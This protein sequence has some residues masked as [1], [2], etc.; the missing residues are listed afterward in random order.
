M[1]SQSVPAQAETEGAAGSP[2]S[3]TDISTHY[4][5]YSVSNGAVMLLGFISFPI[6][7]RFLDNAEFGILR[8]YDTLM[9]L[10]VALV[11]FGAPHAIV[12]FYPYDGDQDRMRAF[13]TN[14]VLLPLILSVSIWSIIAIALVLAQWWGSSALHPLF[15]FA[16]V[17]VL[18]LSNTNIVQMVMRASERSDV[19][20]STRIIARTLEL[21]FVLVAVIVVQQSAL[22][23]YGGKIVAAAL[24]LGW[25]G[26]WMYRHVSV[27][28]QAID[29]KEF[30]NGLLYGMPLM[31]NELAASVLSNMDRV[32]I[33]HITGDFAM[34]GIY[35]IGYA[36]AMQL[37]VFLSATLSEAFTPVV[38]RS[39]EQGGSEAVR[40][41]KTRVLL[42][43]TYAVGA[44]VAMLLVSGHDVLVALSGH[45][46]AASGEVFVVVGI[47]LSLFALFA[48]SNYGLQLKKQTLPVLAITVAA[49][50]VNIWMNFLLI[51]KMGYMGAA[52]ANAISY[53]GLCLAQFII[54][55][56]GL[57]QLPRFHTLMVASGCALLLVAV[58]HGT[59]LFGLQNA[60]ARLL[61]AGAL[62]V[63]L[64]VLPVLVIDAKMRQM[65]LGL[66]RQRL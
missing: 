58:A 21:V 31:A 36:L 22:S 6:L 56:K 20:M 44:I 35:A 37:N 65:A 48:I 54:C 47:T 41:L 14:Q 38:T 1:S 15:W 34:V 59:D 29:L 8:Y 51:P 4:V 26:H 52:W 9:L 63:C 18:L 32:L 64:Y 33:R 2:R 28:R 10:G 53:A 39:Y 5:R 66:W 16:L 40:A 50:L 60:W 46:K 30:R 23:V 24:V 49:A 27:S 62:F 19:L 17:L 12:R 42:P 7:T 57:A 11:K 45:D 55:P 25:L 61:V 3:H 43:M 13:G